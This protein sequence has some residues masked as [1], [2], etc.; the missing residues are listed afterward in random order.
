MKQLTRGVLS[1]FKVQGLVFRVQAS[2]F[3]FD[4]GELR[5]KS[6]VEINNA[7]GLGPGIEHSLRISGQGSGFSL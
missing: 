4:I 1:W 5:F 6:P 2:R 7:Y 3:R